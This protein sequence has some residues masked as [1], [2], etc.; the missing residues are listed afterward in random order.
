M[1]VVRGAGPVTE[2]TPTSAVLTRRFGPAGTVGDLATGQDTETLH[3]LRTGHKPAVPL[4]SA[5]YLRK[6]DMKN[7][8]TKMKSVAAS[9]PFRWGKYLAV[10]VLSLI[11]LPV[12]AAH[13]D[14]MSWELHET[15][16]IGSAQV[17]PGNSLFRAN[18]G[19]SELQIIQNG[20]VIAKVP[21][22][23]IHLTKKAPESE[24]HIL[25]NQM[26]QVQFAGRREAIQFNP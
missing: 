17:E 13:T 12:W 9:L 22:S 16:T 25:N 19:Q 3:S 20:Q 10:L 23:W 11:S 21:C 18:E 24:I 2:L 14:S 15:T 6:I 1:K 26:T 4:R 8:K 5:F 7:I